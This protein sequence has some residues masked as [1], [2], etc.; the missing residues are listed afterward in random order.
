MT[1]HEVELKAYGNMRLKKSVKSY[2]ENMK[3]LQ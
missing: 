2:D 3:E 1:R